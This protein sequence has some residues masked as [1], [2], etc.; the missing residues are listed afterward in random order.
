M[1]NMIKRDIKKAIELLKNGG[2]VVFPTDTAYGV[3]CRM[4]DEKAVA[5][6]FRIRKRPETQAVPVLVNNI[7]MA[8]KYS[9]NLKDEIEQLMRKYWPGA[10]TIVVPCK[11]RLVPE[12]VR[13]GGE[14]IGLRIPNHD[15]PLTII[16]ELQVPILGPSANFHGEPTP[17]SFKDLDPK[18]VKL[19]DYVIKGECP[20]RKV[21]TVIDV[22]QRKWRILREGAVKIK[23]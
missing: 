13:G 20:L 23:I 11:K 4:D 9:K 16:E 7:K 14:T 6:L 1:S 12:L 22:S 15:I 5:K 8:K 3:G 2:I 17:Y 10:L 21:S 19:V 18:F